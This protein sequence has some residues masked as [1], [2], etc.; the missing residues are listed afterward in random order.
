MKQKFIP[1]PY[2]EAEKEILKI[3]RK[4]FENW[5]SRIKNRRGV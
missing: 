2:E 3:Y 5:E 1:K 4:F